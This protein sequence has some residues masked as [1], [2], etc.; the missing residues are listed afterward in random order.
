LEKVDA[1]VLAF[2]IDAVSF[3]LLVTNLKPTVR[4]K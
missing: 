3:N 1:A 4:V 2:R